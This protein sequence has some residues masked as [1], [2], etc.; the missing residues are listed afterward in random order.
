MLF[1]VLVNGKSH[2]GGRMQWSLPDADKPGEWHE[3]DGPVIPCRNGF[4]LTDTPAIWWVRGCT[5]YVAEAEGIV[6]SFDDFR[7][8]KVA[9]KRCRLLRVATD[10]E[11]AAR[12][13]FSAGTH[14]VRSGVAVA[15]GTAEVTAY[16]T[17][18]VRAYDSAR[19]IAYDKA[20]VV[21]H[22]SAE[23]TAHDSAYVGRWK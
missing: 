8:R 7:S 21:A 14:E 5:V 17:S 20:L 10:S 18:E 13:I 19:V 22:N 3:V 2:Y 16:G 9:A 11:L 15:Y 4:H 12:K 23:A 6:G 1:K